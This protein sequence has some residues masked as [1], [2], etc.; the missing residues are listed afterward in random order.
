M[1]GISLI[2]SGRPLLRRRR[3]TGD[4]RQ[5]GDMRHTGDVRQ[6][7]DVGQTVDVRHRVDVRQKGDRRHETED[8]TQETGDRSRPVWDGSGSGSCSW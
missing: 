8:L 4:M 7:V 1:F 3:E 2:C 6:T 5:A